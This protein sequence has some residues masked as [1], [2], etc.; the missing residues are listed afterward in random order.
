MLAKDFA[1]IA[2]F[3]DMNGRK[4]MPSDPL[5]DFFLAG[6]RGLGT[7]GAG[8]FL[9]R[10]YN[11]FEGKCERPNSDVQFLLEVTY[12]NER[13]LSVHDVSQKS[14]SYFDAE[15]NLQTIRKRIRE[16]T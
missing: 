14:Q 4:K 10:C 11:D 3:S 1:I 8:W 9:D 16:N 7:W 6:I 12:K 5:K 13:I 15:N 2:R